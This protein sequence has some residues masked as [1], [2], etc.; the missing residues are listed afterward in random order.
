M[1]I[2]AR[3]P[4][5]YAAADLAQVAT[6]QLMSEL[7]NFE[8]RKTK[9]QLQFLEEEYEISKQ[10]FEAAQVAVAEFLD[11]NQG[12]LSA[13]ARIQEQRLQNDLDLA[14]SIYSNWARQVESTRVQLREDTPIFTVVD[15]VK[16]PS[17]PVR[18]D[19][20]RAILLSLFLGLFWGV[21]YVT[22]V[23]LYN[24]YKPEEF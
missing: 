14:F 6:D 9:D 16:V 20:V 12:L 8:V 11:R 13:T 23:S 22:L 15:P 7:I 19:P 4:D 10:S 24:Y 17:R 5:A 3:M 18:P 2:R 1:I 21:G